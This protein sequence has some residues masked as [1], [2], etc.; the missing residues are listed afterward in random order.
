MA[1]KKTAK[2]TT[3]KKTAAKAIKKPAAKTAAKAKAPTKTTKAAAKSA[4]Q[5]V[6]KATKA[7]AAKKTASKTAAKAVSKTATRAAQKTGGETNVGEQ[8]RYCLEN[9]QLSDQQLF[10]TVGRL[11]Q[12]NLGYSA[13]NFFRNTD[14]SGKG[15]NF[16]LLAATGA[17]PELL[18][19]ADEPTR[20]QHDETGS[21]NSY[22]IKF[23]ARPTD[24]ELLDEGSALQP[25][26]L[27]D[28]STS[29]DSDSADNDES[30][31][32]ALKSIP[33]L[34][35]AT[36]SI[37]YIPFKAP[38]SD[39]RIVGFVAAV[40]VNPRPRYTKSDF[41][42]AT[43]IASLL[44]RNLLH[45]RLVEERVGYESTLTRLRTE[46]EERRQEL[47]GRVKVLE[48]QTGEQ[49][50]IRKKLET[51]LTRITAE[52]GE[53]KTTLQSRNSEFE[54]LKARADLLETAQAKK[55]AEQK[56]EL[57]A[58]LEIQEQEL[59]EKL[60]NREAELDKRKQELQAANARST[61][62]ETR[63]H[64]EREELT[65]RASDAE[66][67]RQD[68]EKRVS[69]QSSEI[70]SLQAKVDTG[71]K[72]Y[73]Q[74]LKRIK[75]EHSAALT[76]AIGG[77]ESQV[78]T[79]RSDYEKQLVELRET[80][81]ARL[82]KREGELSEQITRLSSAKADAGAEQE[83]LTEELEKNAAR[84][85]AAKTEANELQTKVDQLQGELKAAATERSAL[86]DR[87]AKL[88]D[89]LDSMRSARTESEQV[90]TQRAAEN[91]RLQEQLTARTSEI[92]DLK[93]TGETV[94]EELGELKN[95][96]GS[97]DESLQQEQNR[98]AERQKRI[99]SLEQELS[100][101][102]R[103]LS[104]QSNSYDQLL[105]EEQETQA[106]VA[107]ELQKARTAIEQKETDYHN[108]LYDLKQKVNT[109]TETLERT[110]T[111]AKASE[112]QYIREVERLEN[113][114][115]E[116]ETNHAR[117][118]SEQSA[119]ALELEKQLSDSR[120]QST[121]VSD[122]LQIEQQALRESNKTGETLRSEISALQ[123]QLAELGENHA[124]ELS[125]LAEAAK[126]R[127]T[128]YSRELTNRDNALQTS[129]TTIENHENRLEAQGRDL[130]RL[131]EEKGQ[132]NNK[133]SEAGRTEKNLRGELDTG[134]AATKVLQE[135]IAKSKQESQ[136]LRTERDTAREE[137]ARLRQD[138]GI[139]REREARLEQ[140]IAGLKEDIHGLNN[141]LSEANQKE[142]ELDQNIAGLRGSLQST[143]S[144]L[145]E[146]YLK[147]RKLSEE[148]SGALAREK[149]SEEEGRLLASLTNAISNLP[150]FADKIRYLRE[151]VPGRTDIER[152][153][154]YRLTDED[155]LLFED[156]YHGEQRL[157]A[158]RGQ[159]VRLKDTNFGQAMVSLR[160]QRLETSAD[161]KNPDLPGGLEQKLAN[162]GPERSKLASFL[163]L[164]LMESESG[165]G[166]LVLASTK[167][168]AF[169]DKHIRILGNVAP[170]FAVAVQYERNNA[171]L[172]LHRARIHNF[173]QVTHYQEGRYLKTANQL[174]RLS[175][176][177]LPA[178]KDAGQSTGD[179]ETGGG[180]TRIG[181]SEDLLREI[182]DY[183]QLAL[184]GSLQNAV[185]FL[186]WID[187]L[188]GKISSGA[189]L[190][191]E[192]ELSVEILGRLSERIGSGFQNLYWLVSE[193]MEN[194][195]HHSQA[196]QLEILLEEM[197]GRFQFSIVDNGEGL[198][199]TAG[200]DRPEH[201]TGLKAIS[202][203]AEAA[204]AHATFARDKNG[205]GLAV[206]VTWD[207]DEND[208]DATLRVAREIPVV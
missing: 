192:H 92:Q 195:A 148:L 203:L 78:S 4:S 76:S 139:R 93:R 38:G 118:L 190:T 43:L 170:L 88:D 90:N 12:E 80:S 122:E 142:R 188:G 126:S 133:L 46:T 105:K 176:R 11:L 79:L 161:L 22:K 5:T 51:S 157:D 197:D 177:I 162:S 182:N 169:D 30:Y 75:S 117:Q 137:G 37:L 31:P 158:L 113:A 131:R 28:S 73:E 83:L 25:Y 184:P 130:A 166:I 173:K 91:K 103:D 106:T 108:A 144:E 54:T 143:R 97:R 151:N 62:F 48:D 154:V 134:A 10:A 18:Y 64:S 94:T 168:D 71:Q 1:Q 17:G 102:I 196:T 115:Q 150:A 53:Q 109:L 149:G 125:R 172:Q 32:V 42:P 121:R 180:Q 202:N 87:A 208:L 6:K 100:G 164:P 24:N 111:E 82:K 55:L 29:E 36:L 171:E 50:T 152:V 132:L 153:V 155:T 21:T 63:T 57:D 138:I 34:K 81:E 39:D 135:T 70:E 86:D 174:H 58:L 95:N 98:S 9:S 193:A 136:Q 44:Q 96:L 116:L 124:R 163:C 206:Q 69:Q 67:A 110:R 187:T 183:S 179:D 65:V 74:N 204:G 20:D 194:V 27:P 45:F 185:D 26:A 127:E 41:E 159:R 35:E 16:E 198:V 128:E 99:E 49:H 205:H 60:Q 40:L 85:A 72:D 59:R 140:A 2:K 145:S 7:P 147:E 56:Q 175:T 167:A 23:P 14:P 119:R 52:A 114:A 104:E 66:N 129:R 61:E 191:F 200:T 141:R 165:I 15:G 33:E 156:G 120:D 47:E 189:N 181:L 68:L 101:K 3:A 89:E 13:L 19:Y 77:S 178:L 84:V 8:L 146:Q 160:P 201:G 123:T 107:T 112:T 199:R 207:R 186:Q